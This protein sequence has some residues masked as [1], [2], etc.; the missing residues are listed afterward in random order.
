MGF[1]RP[2]GRAAGG[3]FFKPTTKTRFVLSLP[4]LPLS[5]FFVKSMKEWHA[6][7]DREE[8]EVEVEVARAQ[9]RG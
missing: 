8:E 7:L 3:F 6:H 1:T 4:L 2:R 5:S 9:A